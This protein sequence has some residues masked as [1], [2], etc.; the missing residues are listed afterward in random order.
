[1]TH[2]LFKDKDTGKLFFWKD[3]IVPGC[4]NQVCKA[5]GETRFCWPHSKGDKSLKQILELGKKLETL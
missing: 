4:P 5:K 3:C 2:T 1:M